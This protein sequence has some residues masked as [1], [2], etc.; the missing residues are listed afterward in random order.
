ML[1][2]IELTQSKFAIIDEADFE[3]VSRYNWY[4]EHGYARCDIWENN[5][6]QILYMHRLITDAELGQDIH[7]IN[8][9]GLDNR[10][11]NLQICTH[12]ENCQDRNRK[13]TGKGY[14]KVRGC[15]TWQVEKRVNGKRVRINCKTESHAK[16]ILQELCGV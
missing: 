14:H 16:A 7:H 3:L 9:D 15:K 2:K 8:H 13:K 12:V 1:R 10:R 5:K 11:C 6:K 4:F